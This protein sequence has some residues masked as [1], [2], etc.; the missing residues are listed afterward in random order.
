MKKTVIAEIIS[1]LFVALFLY[2]GL[3]KLMEYSV[4][5][6]QI[7]QSPIL[8]PFARWIA[9]LLPMAELVVSLLLFF[10]QGRLQG[11]YASLGL[12]MI[13][14]VYIIAIFSFDKHLPCSCGGIIELLSWKGHLE[15]NGIFILLASLGIRLQRQSGKTSRLSPSFPKY[16]VILI[17]PAFSAGCGQ[18]P[19]FKTGMEG[20][21]LPSFTLL[22]ADSVTHFNTAAITTGRPIVLFCFSPN[23]PYCKA[24][25]EDITANIKKL[26]NIRFYIFT[27]FP[28]RDMKKFYDHYHLQEF[29]NI[30]TGVDDTNFF[31]R[32]YKITGVPYLAVYD[33]H[34][35][36]KQAL[37]G[38]TDAVDI[39]DIAFR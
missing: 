21:P 8:Q 37:N 36:L 2:A 30:T 22:L 17:L 12:M 39:K 24:E 27:M 4:F 11:L 14:T 18:R 29:P 23:C 26:S 9:W 20:K 25:M 7:A 35:R 5:K 34:L 19:E 13:F 32:Y 15:F 16:I 1:L 6:V 33:D 31:A 10:P 38:K 3:S 28:F